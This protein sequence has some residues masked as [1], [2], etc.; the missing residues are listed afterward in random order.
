MIVGKLLIANF[1]KK[2]LYKSQ[3]PQSSISLSSFQL[4]LGSGI[5]VIIAIT[6]CI[7]GL[8]RSNNVNYQ[9]FIKCLEDAKLDPK[10]P[11]LKRKLRKFD[12]EFEA[13][14]VDFDVNQVDGGP[15]KPVNIKFTSVREPSK[16][17]WYSPCQ[18]V[19]YIAVH[20]FGIKMIYPGS[21]QL[22]QKYLRKFQNYRFMSRITTYD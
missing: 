22:V 19:A 21:V 8:G 7:R 1:I 20:T 3:I 12:F 17:S 9:R 15:I 6:L 13:W 10:N 18:I 14:P 5:G 11:D 16:R 2:Y 4:K